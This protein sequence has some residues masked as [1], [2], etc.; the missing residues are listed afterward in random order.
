MVSNIFFHILGIII[1]IDYIIFFRGVAQPPTS[2]QIRANSSFFNEIHIVNAKLW[3]SST[4]R[5]G[6]I[7]HF[8]GDQDGELKRGSKIYCSYGKRVHIAADTRRSSTRSGSWVQRAVREQP[9][10]FCCG[11]KKKNL[12]LNFCNRLWGSWPRLW[13]I[14]STTCGFMDL[15]L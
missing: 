5:V 15:F 9:T 7:S 8:F 1:P 10:D 3:L 11:E 14:H 2:H 6:N 12:S 13:V 4:W